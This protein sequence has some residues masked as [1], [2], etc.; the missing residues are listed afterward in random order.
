VATVQEDVG[1]RER[2][3]EERREIGNV[4]TRQIM[5]EGERMTKE[6]LPH[7]KKKKKKKKKK[8]AINKPKKKIK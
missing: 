8:N 4:L 2:L 5:T 3:L 6:N 1:V 7:K